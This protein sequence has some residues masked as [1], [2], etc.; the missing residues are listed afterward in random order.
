MGDAETERLAREEPE[1]VDEPVRLS[2]ASAVVETV[3]EELGDLELPAL[4]VPLREG[5]T[6]TVGE[7]EPD[8]EGVRLGE[9]EL[10]LDSEPDELAV[11]EEEGVG[12]AVVEPVPEAEGVID[13]VGKLGKAEGVTVTVGEGERDG[14]IV[15]D[16]V[17][18][19]LMVRVA[20]MERVEVRVMELLAVAVGD[21]ETLGED[22][23]E[24]VPRVEAD[25]DGVEAS[26]SDGEAEAED[27][28]EYVP[29]ALGEAEGDE[30][31]VRETLREGAP[32]TEPE[33]VAAGEP[34][35]AW[36]CEATAE[37]DGVEAGLGEALRLVELVLDALTVPEGVGR[38]E[39]LPDLELVDEP[40]LDG[41][42]DTEAVD[43]TVLMSLGLMVVLADS[44]A[45][46]VE[47]LL[48]RVEELEV[49]VVVPV[50]EGVA[51]A[52]CV[53]L[54]VEERLNLGEAEAERLARVEAD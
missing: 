39:A 43:E 7:L 14:Q 29:E 4:V 25:A 48:G 20:V 3:T 6:E 24:V 16:A 34:D 35:G 31:D 11:E 37:R 42:L 27:C 54:P 12:E 33:A 45:E 36:L 40:E 47:L 9:A 19:A 8:L 49:G 53:V 38:G 17:A 28:A 21:V 30:A 46:P 10:V 1:G 23:G 5:R 32:V 18:L 26:M 2:V 41:V 51:L 22:V 44:E 15:P 50:G 13:S 52:V